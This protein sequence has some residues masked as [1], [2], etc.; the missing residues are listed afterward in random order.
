MPEPVRYEVR[1]GIALVVVDNPPVNALGPG[2]REAIEAALARAMAD[3]AVR[4]VVVAGA[5]RT[6]IAGA[7][8]KVFG[9]LKNRE[10]SIERS[11]AV[12]ARLRRIEDSAKPVVAAIHGTALG[13][14]LELAMACHFRVAVPSARVGQPEV[15]LGI[16]PGAGGTQRLPRLC[17]PAAALELCTEGQPISASRARELGIVDELLAEDRLLDDAVAFAR[18][19]A[20]AGRRPKTRERTDRLGDRESGMAACRA[21]RARL[22][23]AQAHAPWAAVDAIEAAVT[24]DF[25]AGSEREI[26]LFADCVT[27]TE[28]RAM[29]HLFFAEREAA[30]VAGV[31]R[32]TP[33]A[34]I[35]RAA[36]VG[37]GTMGTGIAMAYANAGIPVRLKDADQPALLRGL[38]KI[39][40]T[41]QSSAA[42]GK[43][44]ED[45]VAQRLSLI[46]PTT[47]VDGFDEVDIVV[48]A[49]FEDL[50]LKKQ[51]F[52]DLGRLTAPRCILASN[53]STLDVDEFARASGRPDRVI[54]HHFFSP[55]NVMKLLEVVRGR[56]TGPQTIAAS[57]ALAKRLG[58][59]AVVVG[60][61]FGFVANRMLAY[62]LREAHLLLE[63]GASVPQVDG[64]LVQF[65]LPVGPFAMQDIAGI[66]VGARIR[67]HLRAQGL[68]RAEG[69]QSEVPDRLFEMGRYGQKTGAGWY[70]YEPGNRTPLPD[71]LVEGLAAEAAARRGVRR[72]AVFDEEIVARVTTALANEGANILDEGLAA[73]AGDIDVI[74]AYGFGFPRHRGGPMFYADTIGPGTVLGRVREYRERLGEHWRPAPLLERLAAE[75]KGFTT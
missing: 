11:R 25:E 2:V 58:K 7:D 6:F 66:D 23:K 57:L 62:Y 16:I 22:K 38:G 44:S 43:L 36:V 49:M 4:A 5:G 35:R 47:G 34:E 54:G 14:G 33:A 53:T 67:Q 37:A 51:V 65:G 68:T 71:P 30:R 59:V 12:H 39:R 63:E 28:S 48:E 21:T 10:Q 74:Y 31:P 41:Y 17:G 40:E 52:A 26:Q 24:L 73:R 20:E 60:N 42:R 55:A 19:Q 72:R 1:D 45:Q 32:D 61:C 15:R 56:D 75:G 8:I 46:T 18:R 3:P 70:R 50:A 69:P 64:A 13:G 9:A 29:V 27:S